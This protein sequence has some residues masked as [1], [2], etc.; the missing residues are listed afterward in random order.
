MIKKLSLIILAVFFILFLL[1]CKIA[2][3]TRVKTSSETTAE[4]SP[5]IKSAAEAKQE[6]FSETTTAIK[7]TQ[8]G[9]SETAIVETP[10]PVEEK[11]NWIETR[12]SGDLRDKIESISNKK[13]KEAV[14]NDEKA[15]EAIDF[16]NNLGH[17]DLLLDRKTALQDFGF[18]KLY[19]ILKN[20]DKETIDDYVKNV[21]DPVNDNSIAFILT[22]NIEDTATGFSAFIADNHNLPYFI[23]SYKDGS[24]FDSGTN[25]TMDQIDEGW[26]TTGVYPYLS[27]F[28]E[29][30]NNARAYGETENIKTDKTKEE[31]LGYFKELLKKYSCI[32]FFSNGHENSS[33]YLVLY[34]S[35]KVEKLSAL[36]LFETMVPLKENFIFKRIGNNCGDGFD[37]NLNSFL[38]KED[39]ISYSLLSSSK[40][41]K[42]NMSPN[43]LDAMSFAMEY[44]EADL[45]TMEEL[46][47]LGQGE[48][49]TGT[50][51]LNKRSIDYFKTS[52]PGYVLELD[53][54]GPADF[55][56]ELRTNTNDKSLFYIK[57]NYFDFGS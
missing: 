46:Q 23:I 49:K 10:D 47:K 13:Y 37:I 40:G 8:E 51:V 5:D 31:I 45:V 1:S 17:A 34:S 18:V 33:S 24:A 4:A 57:L 32:Y 9:L 36:E 11:L 19:D 28:I 52:I 16:F 44:S 27:D 29:E 2:A 48:E 30:L 56:P 54:G 35:K 20:Y 25:L 14:L 50:Y 21:T 6:G 41:K 38:S 42:L 22:N 7:T 55:E 53:S 26:K 12:Y 15:I 43:I 39:N 3:E